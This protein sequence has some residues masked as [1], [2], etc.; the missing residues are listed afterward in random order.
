VTK[1]IQDLKGTKGIH[2]YPGGKWVIQVIL[3]SE[4]CP[5]E[6]ASMEL[7]EVQER[8]DHQ[9]LRANR[10]VFKISFPFPTLS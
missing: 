1:G 3:D 8:K 7:L 5:G 9:D 10:F 2:L 6:R 4:A